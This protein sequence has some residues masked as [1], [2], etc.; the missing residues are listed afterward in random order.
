MYRYGIKEI[1]SNPEEIEKVVEKK[2]LLYL[3]KNL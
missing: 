2:R 1:D 3:F